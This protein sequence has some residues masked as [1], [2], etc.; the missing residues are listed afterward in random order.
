MV[1][2]VLFIIVL[3]VSFA[4]FFPVAMASGIETM[5][6]WISQ[7]IKLDFTSCVDVELMVDEETLM[8]RDGSLI[9][10]IDYG[11]MMQ[12]PG[13][14]EFDSIRMSLVKAINSNLDADGNHDLQI[15][16][17]QDPS[18][19]SAQIKTVM[20]RSRATARRIGLNIDDMLDD[21]EKTLSG[22]VVSESV[23]IVLITKPG[24]LDPK[25]RAER[26]AENYAKAKSLKLPR[27]GFAQNPVKIVEDLLL[28]HK[29]YVESMKKDVFFRNSFTIA[30]IMSAHEVVAAIRREIQPLSTSMD[31][32]PCLPG[33]RIPATA[34]GY[35]TNP[36]EDIYYPPIWSQVSNSDFEV[37]SSSGMERVFV[38]GMWHG[39]VTMDLPPQTPETFASLSSRLRHIPFRISFRINSS[40]LKAYSF[41][42]NIVDFLSFNPKSNNRRIKAAIDGITEN[43][44]NGIQF[45]DGETMP[46]RAVTF[47][48]TITTW[49]ES[50]KKI[51][52]NMQTISKSLQSW[53]GSDVL[54]RSGD[55]IDL[56]VSG[57]PGVSISTPSRKM[58]FNA[59]DVCT[60][61]PLSRPAAVWKDGSVLLTSTDGKMMPFHPGSSEQKAWVYLLFATMGSGKSVLLNTI[62][63]GMCLA[64][65][66]SKLP[67]MTIIDI[68]E[69]VSGTISIIQSSL[70]EGR[71]HEA[72]YFKVKMSTEYAYNVFDTQLGFEF[73]VARDRD[74]LKNFMSIVC[75][76]AGQGKTPPMMSEL[77]GA[78]VDEAYRQKS[79]QGNPVKYQ[80]GVSSLIDEA[81]KGANIRIDPD[82]TWHEIRD[83]FFKLNR[84]RESMEAQKFAVPT[85]QDIPN[86]LRA[87]AIT[88]VFGRTAE[89][90]NLIE[91]ASIMINSAIRD[92]P[93][94]STYTRWDISQC[95]VAG[96]DLNDVKGYGESGAKQTA[97]MY[98]FAQ[99]SA[100][101]NYYLDHSALQ[102][103]PDM[104]RS[105]HKARID[106][107]RQEIKAVIYDEFHN[108]KGIEGIRK[109]VS[110][111]IREGRKWNIMT[112][113][114]SQLISDFDEDAI[115]NMT[116]TFILGANGNEGVIEKCRSTFGLS[117]SATNALRRDVS[118]PGVG[119]AVFN[120]KNG[121]STMVFRNYLSPIKNWGFSSTAEDKEIRRRLYEAIPAGEARKLLAKH[122]PGSGQFKAYIE[123]QRN[124]MTGTP[125][126][127]GDDV[128]IIDTLAAKLIAE[129]HAQKATG[130][131]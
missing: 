14:A 4:L 24:A 71:K 96:I 114:S 86:V 35:G 3:I 87:G 131:R 99:Q 5:A 2:F 100:A 13:E 123:Q 25:I 93:V 59:F 18:N 67:M 124:N 116:G 126:G 17:R 43:D 92:Y 110:I 64:P 121:V 103:C 10:V 51:K 46:D 58:L 73:P 28:K 11:G 127:Q 61:M 32:R 38:D 12:V 15:I 107:I 88:D 8:R 81:I 97:L 76:P 62:E 120:T 37:S 70:P 9:S 101:R 75:T 44:R 108:T 82:T 111:D 39:T 36:W 74:F 19:T 90:K 6:Q 53:G 7:F 50:E 79:T 78:V 48:V 130:K 106:E 122:W 42:K 118:A 33:D 102:I 91:T 30:E 129:Y 125:S 29:A 47:S 31:Y 119:L 95:R 60:M 85:L 77:M 65:G 45:T 72:G 56:F 41:N 52:S 115:E 109:I 128:S 94:L 27:L 16:Y 112:V 98:A 55:P 117:D 1:F 22:V 80:V 63:I 34:E 21:D 104:Y 105:F 49:D 68:G 89:G 57:L 113:L 83:D 23:W 20:A 26:L 69:S 40:A 54:M 66:L 84:V